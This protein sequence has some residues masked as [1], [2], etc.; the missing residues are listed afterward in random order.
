MQWREQ[1]TAAFT[2][3]PNIEVMVASAQKIGL[4]AA[5][6]D[7]YTYSVEQAKELAMADQSTALAALCKFQNRL[8]EERES[9]LA[10]V[11]LNP[12]VVLR[13][14]NDW[15]VRLGQLASQ[16]KPN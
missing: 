4:L 13:A 14:L 16:A 3:D 5:L 15:W 12:G 2:G 8:N 11:A 7:W 10:Q 9:V 6:D 1:L